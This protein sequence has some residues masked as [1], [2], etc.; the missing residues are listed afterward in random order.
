M[1]VAGVRPADLAPAP[2]RPWWRTALLVIPVAVLAALL[3]AIGWL[4]SSVADTTHTDDARSAALR[5]ASAEAL[6]LT[7][8]SYLTADRDL[9]RILAGATGGL[10]TQ[11]AAQRSRFPALLAQQKSVSRGSVLSAGL[12]SLS[13]GDSSARV[14]V[15][16]DAAVSTTSPS[17]KTQS[18]LKHYRMVMQLVR[19]GSRWL[20][21]DVAFAGLPQ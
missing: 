15:A 10:R 11:F 16:V 3:A 6:H 8:I 1:D 5:A 9:D 12:V 21:R 2:G 19:S 18:S 14:V 7:T 17:G 20:V 4:A 13:G